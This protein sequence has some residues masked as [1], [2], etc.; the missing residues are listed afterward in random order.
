MGKLTLMSDAI[1]ICLDCRE[2]PVDTYGLRRAMGRFVTGVTVV[3]TLTAHGIP[4]GLTA[5]SFSSVSLDPP[6]VLFSLQARAPSLPAFIEAGWFAVNV[7]GSHQHQ[8]SRQFSTPSPDKF[9]GIRHTPGLGGCPLLEGSLARFECRLDNR[10]PAGDHVIVVGRV[11][12][13][14][15]RDGEPLIFAGGR[16][17]VPADFV[18]EQ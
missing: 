8:C 6:L 18:A 12:R 16:Y 13:V 17:C 2:A 1:E 10:M 7:L 3:T 15:H 4:V 5:N 9:D 11:V 14:T